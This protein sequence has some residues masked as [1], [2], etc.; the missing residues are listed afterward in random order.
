MD[1]GNCGCVS[2]VPFSLLLL[3]YHI[4]DLHWSYVGA[5]L[6][7]GKGVVAHLGNGHADI[8]KLQD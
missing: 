5:V 3:A 7:R 4:D 6:Q 2:S 1:K 8:E